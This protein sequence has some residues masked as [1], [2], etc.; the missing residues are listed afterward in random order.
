MRGTSGGVA[1]GNSAS[2]LNKLPK[3][4]LPLCAGSRRGS[5]LFSALEEKCHP[6]ELHVCLVALSCRLSR[7]M[8]DVPRWG[9]WGCAGLLTW[10]MP[11]H[12]RSQMQQ[13]VHFCW[14]LSRSHK[15]L[16]GAAV[17]TNR[18]GRRDQYA[19]MSSQSCS[20]SIIQELSGSCVVFSQHL[21][22]K[23][24]FPLPVWVLLSYSSLMGCKPL[25]CLFWISKA[26]NAHIHSRLLH[27]TAA[28]GH[29]RDENWLTYTDN[30]AVAEGQTNLFDVVILSTF[31]RI[32]GLWCGC[33]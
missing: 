8:Y 15:S 30:P 29:H 1:P 32:N 4:H 9:K 7:K 31:L 16:T 11:K 23:Y 27:L 6:N 5:C 13:T 26:L 24:I 21:S 18:W 19:D 25:F 28:K 12:L 20:P 33:D 10:T 14:S 3:K 17:S 22:T 2:R